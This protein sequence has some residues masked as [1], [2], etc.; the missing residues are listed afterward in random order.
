MT[1]TQATIEADWTSILA[2]ARSD[3]QTR[4]QFSNDPVMISG[5]DGLEEAIDRS[6]E[7][8]ESRVNSHAALVEAL[9]EVKTAILLDRGLSDRLYGFAWD[10]TL[11]R[12]DRALAAAKGTK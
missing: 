2:A 8:I 6:A 3:L 4:W 5:A 9:E 1:T 11:A 12:M 7:E 10:N